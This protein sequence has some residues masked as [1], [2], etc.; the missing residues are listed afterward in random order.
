MFYPVVRV[1]CRVVFLAVGGLVL[2]V[3]LRGLP[4]GIGELRSAICLL[5]T[6]QQLPHVNL[7]FVEIGSIE[8]RPIKI[9]PFRSM[10][11]VVVSLQ[12][13]NGAGI[14]KRGVIEGSF[15]CVYRIFLLE[16]SWPL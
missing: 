2:R 3:V 16:I 8:L 14:G 10:K 4:E 13:S 5:H 9:L 7:R 12:L 1:V 15:G 6:G 11:R